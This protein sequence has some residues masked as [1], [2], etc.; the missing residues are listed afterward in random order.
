MATLKSTGGGNTNSDSFLLLPIRSADASPWLN[1]SR[2][3]RAKRFYVTVMLL[4]KVASLL[5]FKSDGFSFCVLSYC[6]G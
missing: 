5:H 4:M 3:Q 2:S 1:P 6:N